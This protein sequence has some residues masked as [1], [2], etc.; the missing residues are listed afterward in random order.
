MESNKWW[1]NKVKLFQMIDYNPHPKQELI[2]QS[3][4]RFRFLCSGRRFGKTMLASRDA[5]HALMKPNQRGWCVGPTFEISKKVF[6]E[7]FFILN[8]YFQPLIESQSEH[9]QYIRLINGSEIVGKSADNPVSL[10][11]E[12]LNFLIVDEAASIKKEVWDMYLR[13]TL[14]DKQGWALFTSTPR[15]R[16]WFY[17]EWTRGQD[18]MH[19]NYASWNFLTSDNPY[20]PAGEVELAKSTL[21]ERV[22]LQEYLGMFLEDIGGVFRGIRECISGKFES[23]VVGRSYVAGIDLAKHQ[24]YTVITII[25]YETKHVVYFDRFHQLDWNFQKSRIAL[26]CRNYN[27]AK[28][29]VDATGVGDPIFDDL[30]RAGFS[31]DGFKYTSESKAKLIENL[32]LVIQERQVSF[33]EIPELINE[34]NIFEY[35]VSPNTRK[36]SYNAPE[37]YNDDC[38]NSLALAV[39]GLRN[40]VLFGF[41]EA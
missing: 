7:V 22:Y 5:I 9:N 27:N 40:Q 6:R 1:E 38:V 35:K 26:A 32:S 20:I 19:S 31:V 16:N 41:L 11:G 34:L 13:P 14:T 29:V 10:L 39:W 2:H 25:D 12:G 30:R 24:D 8:K 3:T 21:P 15:G 18:S 23:P 28:I 17:E 36:F 4:A 33:P 37:G